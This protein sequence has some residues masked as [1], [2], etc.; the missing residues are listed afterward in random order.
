M[1]PKLQIIHRIILLSHSIVNIFFLTVC[2]VEIIIVLNTFDLGKYMEIL[3]AV[4][5]N[6]DR[7]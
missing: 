5:E 4:K 6:R 2:G 3:F 7:D 1:M